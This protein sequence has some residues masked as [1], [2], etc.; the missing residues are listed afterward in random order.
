[1]GV[2][3]V[4]KPSTQFLPCD[5]FSLMSA[6]ISCA[7]NAEPSFGEGKISTGTFSNASIIPFVIAI[8]TNYFLD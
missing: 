6:A 1:M 7:T 2:E 8:N 3:P 4:A 5:A